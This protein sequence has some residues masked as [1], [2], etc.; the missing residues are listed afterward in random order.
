MHIAIV[1]ELVPSGTYKG[2][3]QTK[4]VFTGKTYDEVYEQVLRAGLESYTLEV[5]EVKCDDKSD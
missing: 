4:A 2:H 5:H 1:L 3:P